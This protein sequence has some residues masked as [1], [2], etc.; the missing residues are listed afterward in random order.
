M[1][2][3]V[4]IPTKNA[5]KQ[6]YRVLEAVM[7][8]KTPWE[9]EVLVIDSG[10][11]DGTIEYVESVEGVRLHQ[12]PANEFGHGK[13]RNLGIS[14]TSGEFAVMITHDALPVNNK[15]LYELVSAVEQDESIAGAFGRHVAYAHDGPFL[16]RDL[17]MHFE[18]FLSSPIVSLENQERYDKD[19]G[20]RQMLH[21]FSDNNACLRRTVWEKMPYPEV[22]F[23]EDQ[24]WA[25][26]IIEAGYAK[27]YAHKA[28]VVHSH[29]FDFIELCRRSFDEARALKRL[30]D[31]EL[32]PTIIQ[33]LGQSV[34]TTFNDVSYLKAEKKLWQNWIWAVRAPFRNTAK[35]IG[36]YLGQRYERLPVGLV[37]FISRDM[38]LKRK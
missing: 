19:I 7:N 4:V 15:W 24:L 9:Y 8:Q 31:Y 36:Y 14:L 18:G 3:S 25:K 32:C 12:I 34:K 17:E 30:F 16:Q 1:K 2:A 38:S 28:V 21:F 23:A 22:D 10:S 35:Q 27:A 11:S 13:T 33:M 29:T 37:R 5:G 26:Q 20:Y 6:F